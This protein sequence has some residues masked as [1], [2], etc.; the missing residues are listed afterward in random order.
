MAALAMLSCIAGAAFLPPA[1]HPMLIPQR[2]A[3]ASVRM[4]REEP[5]EFLKA[6]A[7]AS[8]SGGLATLPVKASALLASGG[9]SASVRA[10]ISSPQWE[11]N[12]YALAVQLSVFAVVYRCSVRMDDND[13]LKQIIIFSFIL[14]RA[15]SS[16][17][18]KSMW[19]PEMWL[20][21]LTYFGESAL[22]FGVAAAA[23]E[24]AWNRGIAYRL[25]GIGVEPTYRVPYGMNP[26]RP[27]YPVNP[28]LPYR[29]PRDPYI[30]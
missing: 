16:T 1:T 30:R 6:G 14:F 18:V 10:L 12:I 28:R 7:I 21:L 13:T 5:G 22:A 11:F 20:Q 27:N 15:F 8:L 3:V 23:L 17:Q 2:P 24:Y 29:D 9:A 4:L 25:P 26:R 19:T